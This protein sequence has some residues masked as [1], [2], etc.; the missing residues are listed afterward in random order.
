MKKTN[1]QYI[2]LP[3]RKNPMFN[4]INDFVLG[5]KLGDGAYA[6]VKKAIHIET[7]EHYAIKIIRLEDLTENEYENVEKELEIH[8]S[9]NHKNI[10]RLYD[11][12]LENNNVYLILEFASKGNL[13]KF[14]NRNIPLPNDIVGK[15]WTQTVDAI[16]FLHQ[17]DIIMRDLKPE[18]IILKDDLTV[19]ICDFGWAARIDHVEYRRLKAGTYI[20]MSPES[21]SGKLQ[22]KPSDLWSLGVLLFEL[23]HYREPFACGIN[24]NEQLKYILEGHIVYSNIIDPRVKEIIEQLLIV[25]TKNRINIKRIQETSYYKE[26]KINNEDKSNHLFPK[27]KISRDLKEEIKNKKKMRKSMSQN[28]IRPKDF[29]NLKSNEKSKFSEP[30][31]VII[32]NP[33]NTLLNLN[34]S[35]IESSNLN[36]INSNSKYST[37]QNWFDYSK[38]SQAT[39]NSLNFSNT[40]SQQ[41][42]NLSHMKWE[43]KK[44]NSNRYISSFHQNNNSNLNESFKKKILPK[45]NFEPKISKLSNNPLKQNKSNKNLNN[46]KKP[47]QMI[48]HRKHL[49][50]GNLQ[51]K[52]NFTFLK[53]Q[54]EKEKIIPA[55]ISNTVERKNKEEFT[56]PTSN[57]KYSKNV[58]NK[59]QINLKTYKITRASKLAGT[60]I[61][62]KNRFNINNNFNFDIVDKNNSDEKQIKAKL[63]GS[64]EDDKLETR[65]SSMNK[66]IENIVD[67]RKESDSILFLKKNPKSIEKVFGKKYKPKKIRLEDYYKR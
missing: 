17:N 42:S 18:N 58:S 6:V 28:K 26:F 40:I 65:D 22:N 15:L 4:S 45:T 34:S 44:N 53:N 30:I 56:F 10:I 19:K 5:R 67:N 51:L 20:Y 38:K 63:E 27:K 29:M 9:L 60:I 48:L 61:P 33:K 47:S 62:S 12:F 25:E 50:V 23:I 11:F 57:T 31:N 52:N 16:H 1:K 2:N 43:L 54:N 7:N 46:F 32:E 39:N 41:S 3:K 59:R 37:S 14:M 66:F 13:F 64:I 55:S 8:S 36:K 21:L 35:T 49:S 24:C